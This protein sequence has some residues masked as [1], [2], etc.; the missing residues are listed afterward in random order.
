MKN[1]VLLKS[2]KNNRHFTWRPIHFWSYVAHF[3]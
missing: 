2:S 1:Q 3:F